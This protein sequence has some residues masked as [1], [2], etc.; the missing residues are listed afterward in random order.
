[1]VASSRSPSAS[2]Q[3]SESNQRLSV[4]IRPADIIG[5]ATRI[6]SMLVRVTSPHAIAWS[7]ARSTSPCSSNQ[8]EARACSP[9][10]ASGSV[11]SSCR[12][13]TSAKRWWYRYSDPGRVEWDEKEVRALDVGEHRGGVGALEDG[14]AQGRRQS[15]EHRRVRHEISDARLCRGQDV[16]GEVVEDVAHV[17]R[18]LVDETPG[19]RLLL[20]DDRSQT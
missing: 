15:L 2:G 17:A 14:V 16:A 19:V 1:M 20:E 9:G 7:M 11:A 6:R 5:T 18:E 3:E 8:S 4:V 10:T 13:K 12:L